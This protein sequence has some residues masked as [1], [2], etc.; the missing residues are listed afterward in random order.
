MTKTTNYSLPQ[1]EAS[2]AL[3]CADFNAAMESI[4]T[5]MKATD[6]IAQAAWTDDNKPYVTGSVSVSA[7]LAV[8]GTAKTFDFEPT[9]VIVSASSVGL[10]RQNSSARVCTD[11]TYIS[12]GSYYLTFRLSGNQLTLSNRGTNSNMS[13]SLSYMAFR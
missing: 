6:D 3:K 7:D 4:D 5:A 2:D 1:W 12:N 9:F 10:I 8:G 11:L 13:T